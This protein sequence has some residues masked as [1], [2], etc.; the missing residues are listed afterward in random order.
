MG[1]EDP[2]NPAR[3]AHP[4]FVVPDLDMVAARLRALG[5]EVDESQRDSFAGHVR[6]HTFDGHGN[7]VEV[8][9]AA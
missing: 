5:F 1:V 3:K 7:R 6:F 4:A 8:L 9:A 2:F